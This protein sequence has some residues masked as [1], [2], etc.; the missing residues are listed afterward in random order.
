MGKHLTDEQ[1]AKAIGALA[2]LVRDDVQADYEDLKSKKQVAETL[3]ISSLDNN[4]H[5][6]FLDYIAK[7]EALDNY[8]REFKNII[9]D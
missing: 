3:F 8:I 5:K 6:L 2:Q 1:I 4:Q 7:K 9:I